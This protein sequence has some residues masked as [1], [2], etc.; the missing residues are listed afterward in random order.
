MPYTYLIGWSKLNKFYYGARWAK[1]SSPNDL[2]VTYFTSSRHVHQFREQ[3]GEPDVV[4]I[5]K[6]FDD[7]QKCKDYELK[8][9]TKLNVLNND[10]WLNK[11]INGAFLPHGKQS[12]EHVKKRMSLIVEA[13]KRNDT[14]KHS[15]E[16]KAK[17]GKSA[18]IRFKGVK[19]TPEHIAKM[20]LRPQNTLNAEC[21][22][23]HK[24]GD[25]KNMKRWHF[26]NCK[27]Q[28][29]RHS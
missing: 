22:H 21:P 11:N 10:R 28:S 4:Q 13:R 8:V 5:R 1:N 2:W 27:Y 17:I 18:S 29:Q 24:I 16:T 3:F 12:S 23:C 26:D 7:P 9:L 20:K 25:Y 14:Y 19:K 6:T 15:D